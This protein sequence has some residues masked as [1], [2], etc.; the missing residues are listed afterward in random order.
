MPTTEN[1]I[2]QGGA[3]FGNGSI[4]QRTKGRLKDLIKR[5]PQNVFLYDTSA[6]GSK[7]SGEARKLPKNMEF[8]V[9]GPDPYS[10]R[11]WYATVY[12]GRDG[13]LKVK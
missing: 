13:K 5:E 9:V 8:L 4:V 11:D 3:E 10:K 7:F 1:I 2:I 6:H 12:W